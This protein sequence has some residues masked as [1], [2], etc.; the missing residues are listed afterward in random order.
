MVDQLDPPGT[1][2]RVT[3]RPQAARRRLPRLTELRRLIGLKRPRFN[4]QARRLESAHSIIDLRRQAMNRTPR[5]VFDYVDGAAEAE[6]SI[7]RSRRAWADV[8]FRP[9]VLRDVSRV[10]TST[11]ILGEPSSLPIVLGPTGFTRMM[12][13]EGEVAVARAAQHLGIPYVLSTMGTTS[14][15]R[16]A[17]ESPD[18]TRWFQLYVWRDRD[19]MRDLLE[20]ARASGHTA[21]VLTVD[22]PIQGARL[23]DIRN[24][25]TIPPALTLRTLLGM[26]R[27]P[28]WWANLLTTEP[29]EFATFSAFDVSPSELVDLLFDTSIDMD[30]LSELKEMWGGPLIV[31]GVQTVE[32]AKEVVDHGAD[33]VLLSNH[34]GRQLDRA[35]TPL[36]LLPEVVAAIGDRAEVYVD[37]G[38]L[39]GGDALA[40]VALG[41]TAC[42][43]GRAY[44]YGLMAGGQDG[45]QRAGEIL[46]A[47][48]ERTMILLGVTSIDQLGTEH[49]RLRLPG[50]P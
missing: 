4:R 21:L 3:A 45:V 22:V 38:I 47:D 28:A 19:A 16:L 8:E 20:R 25:L 33:G 39:N 43:V 36:E 15:E 48:V 10:D 46:R 34:G 49:V 26:A 18:V 24:G 32:D 13:Y 42:F 31:K 23:R 35:P 41:A 37:G 29:L 2:E 44:L 30:A 5:A 40:A 17:A 12:H 11:T 7:R 9:R 1:R 6:H 50:Q 14:P 27:Y